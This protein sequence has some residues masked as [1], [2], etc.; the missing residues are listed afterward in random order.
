MI[1]TGSSRSGLPQAPNIIVPWHS[2]LTWTPVNLGVR[3]LMPSPYAGLRCPPG[4]A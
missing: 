4:F 3:M 1:R 2:G